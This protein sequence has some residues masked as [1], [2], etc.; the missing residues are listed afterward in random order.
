VLGK[1]TEISGRKS[2]CPKR[3]QDTYRYQYI[4]NMIAITLYSSQL[5][6]SS[7]SSDGLS[8]ERFP[9]AFRNLDDGVCDCHA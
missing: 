7:R 1:L 9:R 8:L 3:V 5:D 6:L 4:D 2:V